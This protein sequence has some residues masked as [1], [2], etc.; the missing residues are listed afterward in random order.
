VSSLIKAVI[1]GTALTLSASPDLLA[2]Q[3]PTRP[4]GSPAQYNAIPTTRVKLGAPT[5]PGTRVPWVSEQQSRPQADVGPRLPEQVQPAVSKLD[6]DEAPAPP[7]DVL[8][9]P[10]TTILIVLLIVLIVVAA[11]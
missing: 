3:A 5:L 1:V 4:A 10:V 11:D 9:I 8:I 2:Q 6:A 7:N